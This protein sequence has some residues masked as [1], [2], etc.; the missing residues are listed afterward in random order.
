MGPSDSGKSTL[1]TLMGGLQKQN[2]GEILFE[3]RS[4]NSI[5]QKEL[6]KLRFD[7]IGFI[8]QQSNLIPYL[9][10]KDQ[11]KF[12]D[13]IAKRKY[14]SKKANNLMEKMDIFKR[15]ELYPEQLSRGEKQRASICRD[16]YNSPK[17]IL[18]DETT[19]SLDTNRAIQVVQLLNEN[20]KENNRT[21]V[22]ATHDERLLKYFDRIFR[23]VDG[24][25]TE[26]K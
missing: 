25:L 23:I 5:K 19:A 24:E 2:E 6:N 26:K 4:I 22:M 14:D 1:L 12:I 18:A 9:K 8:L 10:I 21:T 13:H 15:K 20:T 3:S 17:L 16:L 11:F 7:K